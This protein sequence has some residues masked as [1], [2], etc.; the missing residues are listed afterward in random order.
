MR[1]NYTSRGRI[2]PTTS[3]RNTSIVR[4]NNWR[5]NYH[6]KKKVLLRISLPES[7]IIH[8]LQK[9]KI[10]FD[11]LVLNFLKNLN[12]SPISIFFNYNLLKNIEKLQVG[13]N[14]RFLKTFKSRHTENI[15]WLWD[16]NLR[17]SSP[18]IMTNSEL[19]FISALSCFSARNLW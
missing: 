9:Y 14:W 18:Q 3:V 15:Y 4:K 19:L 2:N 6:L 12:S 13:G 10:F 5:I 7:W 16:V 1:T 17:L 11:H 8:T